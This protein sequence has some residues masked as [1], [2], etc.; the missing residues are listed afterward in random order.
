MVPHSKFIYSVAVCRGKNCGFREVCTLGNNGFPIC[1][2]SQPCAGNKRKPVCGYSNGKQYNNECELLKDE[3]HSGS[4]IGVMKGP[5]K[6]KTK[7]A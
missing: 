5:C 2:C 4:V 7:I 6:S 1:T 3:C